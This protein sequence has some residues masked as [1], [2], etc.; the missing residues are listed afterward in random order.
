MSEASRANGLRPNTYRKFYLLP[1]CYLVRPRR[2]RKSRMRHRSFRKAA[3]AGSTGA[4]GI[5]YRQRVPGQAMLGC[6][7]KRLLHACAHP[8]L[9][10]PPKPRRL[11]V[12]IA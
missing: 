7:A 4:A 9:T 11:P 3:L 12:C 6:A 5:R 1:S 10:G 8:G 2:R